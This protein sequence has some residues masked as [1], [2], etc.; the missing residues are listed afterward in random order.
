MSKHAEIIMRAES[1]IDGLE[2]L[3]TRK[4]N[5]AGEIRHGV[6]LLNGKHG[7]ERY[8]K[9]GTFTNIG[10]AFRAYKL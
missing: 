9:V 1:T 6:V 4:T 2:V 8:S 7:Y 10:K 5:K 3:L